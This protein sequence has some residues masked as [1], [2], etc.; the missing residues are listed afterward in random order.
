MTTAGAAAAAAAL[1]LH[2]TPVKQQPTSP[3]QRQYGRSNSL[4]NANRSNSL[5]QYTYYPRVT[6]IMDY[7]EDTI[8]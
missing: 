2:S 3:T 8:A 5:R 6:M 4:S 7:Q 1:R